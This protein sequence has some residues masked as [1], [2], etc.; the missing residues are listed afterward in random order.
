M[1]SIS[2]PCRIGLLV[3]ACAAFLGATNAVATPITYKDRAAF[4]AKIAPILGVNEDVLNFDGTAKGTVVASGSALGGVTFSYSLGG[5]PPYQIGVNGFPNYY[6][7]SGTNYLGV[8]NTI[9]NNIGSNFTTFIGGDQIGFSFD[10]SHAFGM[11]V[12]VPSSWSFLPG[13]INLTFGGT[14]LSTVAADVVAI[15]DPANDFD[16]SN[17]VAALF[18][19]IVDPS[20]T[21][22]SASLTFGTAGTY[23]IDD[24][25][26]TSATTPGPLPEPASL[27]LLGLG[28]LSLGVVRRKSA[29]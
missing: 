10:A 1:N 9:N 17:D 23:E 15:F 26:K 8:S 2:M 20:A 29:A 22:T 4:D 12:I 19:G 13:D 24:I 21:F 27:A 18:L 6:G 25:V 14:T 16:P 28:L 7:T 11:Y 5:T 3:G